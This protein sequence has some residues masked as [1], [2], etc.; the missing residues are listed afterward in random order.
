MTSTEPEIRPDVW[1]EPWGLPETFLLLCLALC[2]LVGAVVFFLP[3]DFIADEGEYLGEII[4]LANGT[5][6]GWII[7]SFVYPAL[8]APG[9]VISDALRFSDPESL[10]H[11]ARL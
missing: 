7:R 6:E 10:T 3:Y 1:C 2:G 8:L 5:P 11:A 4:S 9:V